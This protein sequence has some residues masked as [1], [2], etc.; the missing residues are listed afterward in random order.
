MAEQL[1]SEIIS[2]AAFKQVEQLQA[3]MTNLMKSFESAASS[4]S[5]FDKQLRG[6]KGGDL[7]K[8]LK[9]LA[10]TQ[11]KLE[12]NAIDLDKTNQKKIATE[13]ALQA[14]T[15]SRTKELAA[16]K[17]ALQD[18]NASLK[19]SIKL[20]NAKEGSLNQLRLQLKQATKEYD[21][22]SAS[23]RN[24]ASGTEQLKKIQG[25]DT[26]LKKLEATTG[27]FQ[28]N[29]GNYQGSAKI[30]VDA[31]ERSRIKLADVEKQ[32]GSM[33]PEAS[34]A[35]REFDGLNRI[36]QNP[37]FLNISAKVGDTTAELKFFGK[38][39]NQLQDAGLKNSAVYKDVEDRLIHLTRQIGDTRKEVKAFASDTR[40]FDLFAGSVK[41]AA[42]TFQTA[43]GAAT[44]FG[45]SEED[46]AK[47]IQTLVA[48]QSV[49]NGLKGIATELTTKGTAANKAFA[50]AQ[51]QVKIAMDATATAGARLKAALITTGIGALI[52]GVGLLIANLSKLKNLFG[53]VSDE[54]EK[55]NDALKEGAKNAAVER[56][57][58][59][60]LYKA[61]TTTANGI[62]A[63][64]KAAVE[65]QKTYPLT[66]GNF[67]TEEI[68]L[69]KAKSGYDKL[70]KSILA[71]S[72]L[73]AKQ[74]LI[75]KNAMKFAEDQQDIDNKIAELTDR[76]A[77]TKI[78]RLNEVLRKQIENLK[79]E[80]EE[81]QKAF[82]KENDDIVKSLE[83]DKISAETAQNE[84]EERIKKENEKNNKNTNSNT[85]QDKFSESDLDIERLKRKIEDE[86]TFAEDEKNILGLR[87][88]AFDQFVKDKGL[89]IDKEEEEE[90][91][92]T[93][94]PLEKLNIEEKA[95]AKRKEL[96]R[97]STAERIQMI[98][99]ENKKVEK[100]RKDDLDKQLSDLEKGF[101]IKKNKEEELRDQALLENQNAFNSGV[102]TEEA[103]NK[104][105]DSIQKDFE[106]KSLT[107]QIN[108]YE[109]QLNI[110]KAFGVDVTA[111][112]SAIAQARLKAAQLQQPSTT[113][114][115][116]KSPEEKTLDVL[117]K[118]QK[119][120]SDYSSFAIGISNAITQRKLNN[121]Q[122]EMDAAD[123]QKQIDI[124]RIN[125]SA[126]SEEN[127]AARI[128]IVEA[129]A[130]AQKDALEK[131]KRDAQ[132]KQAQF[133]KAWS[134][135]E[136]ILRTAIAVMTALSDKTLLGPAR[137]AA[138]ITAGAIG[139]GQLAVAIATPIPKYAKGRKGGR[140]EFALVGEAGAERIEHKDGK[141]YMAY[142]PAITYL[143]EGAKV[144]SNPD[145]IRESLNKAA[146]SSMYVNNNGQL[147]Q[148]SSNMES[149][150][151]KHADRIIHA[152]RDNKTVIN[153]VRTWKGDEISMEKTAAYIKW[154]NDNIRL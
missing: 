132:Q 10:D 56:N 88:L 21:A 98:D 91:S 63:Q 55:M 124:D 78:G 66:F 123:K 103:F 140:A 46:A 62:D 22:L 130:A 115:K 110:L 90:K 120:Y 9:E 95:N 105:R 38:Q 153:V 61:A 129:R 59:D 51:L 94:N 149:A 96:A 77:K 37:E 87:L 133:E 122:A 150:L 127:K 116:E 128:Q 50:F 30:I 108:Y 45:A 53:G 57:N 118:L 60:Q 33:S 154:V 152:Y 27:R 26:E 151:E 143:P 12:Q 32:F 99:D 58:L 20:D 113:E 93:T 145:L 70:S 104:K 15:E 126:D 148:Q 139:A 16:L 44:L 111:I 1:I 71:A 39:L 29:V 11:K 109:A 102:I 5:D 6:A 137:I 144:I 18:G 68:L 135:G 40:G 49:S 52:V 42:D 75:D 86:K 23:E 131:K 17:I 4:A 3:D 79:K 142:K 119:A 35:R 83:V 147:V 47:A 67:T 8:A 138:A 73:K 28:R 134:I 72:I 114:I 74:A 7:T 82:K 19:D 125:A 34:A 54:Q 106:S 141:S 31:F 146:R 89:L 41:F 81:N 25:L 136:I 43:A 107:N 48:I 69:G 100:K 92:K 97:Q 14:L 117:Q 65:L 112:E 101:N 84:E 85:K 64:R 2:P 76:R 121:I 24:S 13:K 80:K 36:T